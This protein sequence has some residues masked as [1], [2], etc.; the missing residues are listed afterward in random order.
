MLINFKPWHLDMMRLSDSVRDILGKYP[1]G[2]V[3]AGLAA[4]G[5]AYTIV[6][7]EGDEV[8]ILGVVGAAPIREG[9]AAEVFVVAAEARRAS[10]VAFV[11][12][13]RRSLDYVKGR[14]AKIE[15]VAGDG[16][17]SR[18]FTMLGFEEAGGGRW[19]LARGGEA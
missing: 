7:D 14:F 18:W 15:A 19:C 13:V 1:S 5:L 10:H 2:E 11:K 12:G 6:A 4:V 16:V 8:R 9:A 17:P 3:I